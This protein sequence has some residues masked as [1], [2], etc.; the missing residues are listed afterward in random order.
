MN[1]KLGFP[2]L[3]KA[4]ASALLLILQLKA[5]SQIPV[6]LEPKHHPILQNNFVRVLDVRIPP[7]DTTLFHIH[8]TPSVFVVLNPVHT[9]S[10]VKQESH[11]Y[12]R[13]AEDPNIWYEQLEESPR[14]HRVWNA[15]TALFHVMDIELPHH[16]S[17]GPTHN[18][19]PPGLQVLFNE[20]P[21]R[22][23]KLLL[24]PQATYNMHH[25]LS[26]VLFIRLTDQNDGQAL[27][28]RKPLNEKGQ[29][30]FLNK[31]QSAS[32]SNRASAPVS[33]A[34]LEIQ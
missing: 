24:A 1:T 30:Y 12:K 18:P 22:V 31:G 14:I 32:L 26:Y 20:K 28:N 29:I 27:I 8:A 34:V 4:A 33:F 2:F 15:D 9:G 21:V 13:T 5:T 3:P 7:G 23:S 10:E 6:R 11:G 19:P 16:T 17:E 25:A